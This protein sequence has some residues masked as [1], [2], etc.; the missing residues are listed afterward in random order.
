MTRGRVIY[1]ILTLILMGLVTGLGEATYAIWS[2]QFL[3]G[4]SKAFSIL[5]IA[6]I[7]KQLTTVPSLLKRSGKGVSWV[8]REGPL[9]HHNP[10]IRANV[11][12]T[13]GAFGR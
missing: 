6:K 2:A 7:D 8:A 3:A 10:I 4:R 9:S 5:G 11:E 1:D 12:L 13:L